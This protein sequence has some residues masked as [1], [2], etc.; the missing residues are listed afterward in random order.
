[1][2]RAQVLSTQQ[3]CPSVDRVGTPMKMKSVVVAVAV[4]DLPKDELV[5]W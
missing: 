3:C 2:V 5:L 1:M 4:V